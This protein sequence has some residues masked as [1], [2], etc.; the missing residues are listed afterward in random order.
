MQLGFPQRVANHRWAATRWL[1][2]LQYFP[3]PLL[4]SE[5]EIRF[6]FENM[7]VFLTRIFVGHKNLWGSQ[8]TIRDNFPSLQDLYTY[9]DIF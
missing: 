3:K 2:S 9:S 5:A 8:I 4:A 7:H 1:T 6:F